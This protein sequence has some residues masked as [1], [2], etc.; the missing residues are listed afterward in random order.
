MEKNKLIYIGEKYYCV[1][2]LKRLFVVMFFL[3]LQ[4]NISGQS[5]F[6]F[7]H[8][9]TIGYSHGL[10]HP[11]M[12]TLNGT[13][14]RF[15]YQRVLNRRFSIIL[16]YGFSKNSIKYRYPNNEP[17]FK[18]SSVD[19]FNPQNV[20]TE[21]LTPQ[22]ESYYRSNMF[23]IG[24]RRYF[25][26]KGAIAPYGAFIEA[27]CGFARLNQLPGDDGLYFKNDSNIIIPNLYLANYSINH[28][29]F[30]N[31]QIGVGSSRHLYKN[32]SIDYL[33]NFNINTVLWT[34]NVH[35]PDYYYRDVFLYRCIRN[36]YVR[37]SF[38]RFNIGLH[39]GF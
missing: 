2:S 13:Q 22:G 6:G 18:L 27:K 10:I 4:K 29:D 28:L 11:N 39:Y 36:A 24:F 5:G 16:D 1:L 23:S 3:I 7:N 8:Y 26:S 17:R 34:G 14:H 37:N 33:I 35:G 21:R 15:V 30:V 20:I 25:F 9:N 38:L 12:F 31:V 32:F 19:S